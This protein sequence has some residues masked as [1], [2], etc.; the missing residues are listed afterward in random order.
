MNWIIYELCF[1]KAQNCTYLEDRSF[2]FPRSIDIILPALLNFSID[3][4]KDQEKNIF[5]NNRRELF[6]IIGL[7]NSKKNIQ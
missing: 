4:N 5:E 2:F 6:G 7:F 3:N 1:L